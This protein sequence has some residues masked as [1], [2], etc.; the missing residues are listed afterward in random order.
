MSIIKH[1]D[2]TT[3][4]NDGITMI[5][6]GTND[7][8]FDTIFGIPSSKPVKD[9]KATSGVEVIDCSFSI[10]HEGVLIHFDVYRS[11]L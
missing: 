9:I 7:S 1:F 10:Y 8:Y 5:S 2:L 11:P 3:I 6:T 4:V